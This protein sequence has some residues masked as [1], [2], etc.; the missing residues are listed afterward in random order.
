MQYS[1]NIFIYHRKK[2]GQMFCVCVTTTRKASIYTRSFFLFLSLYILDDILNK[3]LPSRYQ[4]HGNFISIYS[5]NCTDMALL[6]QIPSLAYYN[7]WHTFASCVLYY[8]LCD[9]PKPSH[10]LQEQCAMNGNGGCMG[11]NINMIN[12]ADIWICKP[13]QRCS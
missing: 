4:L 9:S 13:K 11:N 8:L 6:K 10:D 5:Q 12:T 1:A 2:G 3:E 7:M